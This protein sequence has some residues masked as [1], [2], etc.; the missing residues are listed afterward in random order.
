MRKTLFYFIVLFS[1]LVFSQQNE[2]D[3]I[4]HI[5][6]NYKQFD[7]TYVNL[8]THFSKRTLSLR[9]QDTFQIDF[10]KQ[11]L[12]VSE[13][14]GFNKGIL[15][16]YQVIGVVHQYILSNPYIALD[17]YHKAMDVGSSDPSLQ[18]ASLKLNS[19]LGVLY[20]E[21][22]EFK[23]AIPYFKKIIKKHPS[24]GS[25]ETLGNIYGELKKND[26][27]LYYLNKALVL[28]RKA[29]NY[30]YLSHTLSNLAL[31]KSRIQQSDSAKVNIEES[32]AL[33]NKHN[34]ELVRIPVY[35][36]ASE[37]YMNNS[38]LQN[39]EK[40]ALNALSSKQSLRNASLEKA[41]WETL[42]KIYKKQEDYK[43]AL[44]AQTKFTFLKDS[45]INNSKK[46]EL[47][48]KQ[49]QFEAD[50]EKLLAQNEIERQK[51]LANSA[52]ATGF[53]LLFSGLIGFLFF[54]KKQKSDFNAKVSATE[55]KALQA[56]MNPHFI[57]NSLNSINSY[58]IQNDT[59][60]ATSYL[61]KFSKLIRKTL[62]NSTEKEVLLK[63]DIEVLKNYLEIEQKRLNKIFTYSII[64]SDTIDVNNT[65]IP[66]LILQPF[67]EN[68]IWHGI[69]QMENSGHIGIE[70]KKENNM[71]FCTVDDNGVGRKQ[72]IKDPK[73]NTSLGI[74]LTKNR[75]DIINAQNK[76]KGSLR[77]IDKEQGV[78]VEV[79]LPLKFEF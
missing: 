13:A 7:T 78:R 59:E 2:L 72:T 37:V 10:A 57:F 36:N 30:I 21:L 68:S 22:E 25:Y 73:E 31:I 8:R 6:E 69:A 18:I 34:L 27:A 79:K 49:I 56:Q 64:V 39:A 65:L 17:Y 54:K 77:I 62:E 23:K 11:T 71:L 45:L 41:I 61:T 29:K 66:P 38:D 60:S 76:T 35:L 50:K 51:N 67:L 58:I 26:S 44:Y 46:L 47:S 24:F 33:L 40:Y 52:I 9:P 75:I 28:E 48:R 42:Y 53:I 12:K 16:S 63:D 74:T 15:D 3:S 4:S 20:Y 32:L 55:L 70:F 19:Y 1:S 5:I 14:I 43:Q